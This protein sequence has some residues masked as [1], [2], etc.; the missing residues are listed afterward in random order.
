MTQHTQLIIG[1]LILCLLFGFVG[2]YVAWDVFLG[3]RMRRRETAYRNDLIKLQGALNAARLENLRRSAP[4]ATLRLP[5][6]LNEALVEPMADNG[7][8]SRKAE[9]RAV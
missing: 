1:S 9:L 7:N 3:A 6:D 8:W 2:G 5:R 4:R